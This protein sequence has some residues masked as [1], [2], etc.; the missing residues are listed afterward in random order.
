MSI[1]CSFRIRCDICGVAADYQPW[2][3]LQTAQEDAIESGWR[4]PTVLDESGKDLCPY[5][6]EHEEN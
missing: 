2:L 5:C 1:E 4:V 3:S 6:Q